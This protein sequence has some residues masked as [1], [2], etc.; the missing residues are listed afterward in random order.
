MWTAIFELNKGALLPA[1]DAFA[2]DFARL[3]E[4]VAL[5]DSATI[6][7]RLAAAQENRSNYDGD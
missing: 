1:M 5:G 4:A 6:H 7:A 3:R 2:E